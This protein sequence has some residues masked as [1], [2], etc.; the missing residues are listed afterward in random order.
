MRPPREKEERPD[1]TSIVPASKPRSYAPSRSTQATSGPRWA[2]VREFPLTQ[3]RQRPM[4][5]GSPGGLQNYIYGQP[6]GLHEVSSYFRWHQEH[7]HQ[8]RAGRP[9][10]QTELPNPA[11]SAFPPRRT[12]HPVAGPGAAWRFISGQEPR[13]PMCGLGWKSLGVLELTAL[14]SIDEELWVPMVQETDALL[15]DGGDSLYLCHWM[16]QSGLADLLPSLRETVWVGLSAGSM[17]MTPNVGED[18]VIWKPPTGG[19][20]SA[21]NRRLLDLPA[22]GPRSS[23]GEHHGRRR[24]VGRRL[25]VRRTRSTMR[26]PSK[27]STAASKSSPRGTGNCSPGRTESPATGDGRF[28]MLVHP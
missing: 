4:S 17:V 22:P 25:V 21:G 11:P 15:V 5:Y 27:W 20:Q 16:R 7:E 24:T 14:P 8:R 13:C 23:A 18:V 19:P 28:R 2:S 3:P 10:G 26:P 1:P 6:G 12:G 9:P